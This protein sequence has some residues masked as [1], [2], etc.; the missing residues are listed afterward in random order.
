MIV[1]QQTEN[2]ATPDHLLHQ[3]NTVDEQYVADRASHGTGCIT[4]TV[5]RTMEE[6]PHDSIH[7]EY[8]DQ[9][10]RLTSILRFERTS[11]SQYKN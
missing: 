9:Y 6:T 2:L 4:Q 10:S 7:D 1:A 3:D 5:Y 8:Q 11:K